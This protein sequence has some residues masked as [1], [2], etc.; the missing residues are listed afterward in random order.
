M[1]TES[2]DHIGGID[3]PLL[4]HTQRRP[5]T[6][7]LTSSE[8]NTDGMLTYRFKPNICSAL[9]YSRTCL[10]CFDCIE[11]SRAQKRAASTRMQ[12]LV[13][14]NREFVS[15]AVAS[16]R[17]EEPPPR[18]VLN[19]DNTRLRQPTKSGFMD[20][21]RVRLAEDQRHRRFVLRARLPR[22]GEFLT[23]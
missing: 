2:H 21:T 22:Q 23:A 17:S 9:G 15:A 1:N 12:S 20:T 10:D 6:E 4:A 19:A 11:E 5:A 18:V 8:A 13:R 3:P 16:R 14:L 7:G